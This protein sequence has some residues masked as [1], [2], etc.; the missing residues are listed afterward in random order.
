MYLLLWRFGLHIRHGA[1][2]V[3][4]NLAPAVLLDLINLL[5]FALGFFVCVLLCLLVAARLLSAAC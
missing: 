4:D 1:Q 5:E 2:Q 3:V